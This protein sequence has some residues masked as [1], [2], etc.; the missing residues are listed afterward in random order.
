MFVVL[1]FHSE[2][3]DDN[4]TGS[5]T[6][7]Y[8]KELIRIFFV[9]LERLVS[10]AL[11]VGMAV[12]IMLAAWSFLRLT[13]FVASDPGVDILYTTFQTL[14][15]RL[16]AAIIA[17]ELARSVLLLVEGHRGLVQVRII[18]VIGL[19]A[20]VRKLILIELEAADATLVLALA[21]AILALAASLALVMYIDPRKDRDE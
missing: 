17:L 6:V 2:K 8:M 20:V 19:L 14:F 21:A 5:V 18:L 10:T 11:L 15:D 16:L 12:V 3:V 7:V 9:Y 4:P 1:V 13:Y